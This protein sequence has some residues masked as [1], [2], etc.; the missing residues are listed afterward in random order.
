MSSTDRAFNQV[1]AILGKLDRSIDEAR[2]RR[3]N[4]EQPQVVPSTP[5]EPPRFGR[6]QPLRDKPE[7]P[8]RASPLHRWQ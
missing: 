4:E 8:R 7:R 6:A 3:L 2:R 5:V 1:K